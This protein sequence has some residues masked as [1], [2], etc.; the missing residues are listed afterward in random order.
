MAKNKYFFGVLL[1]QGSCCNTKIL[2]YPNA[3]ESQNLKRLVF[4]RFNLTR[5][6][7]SGVQISCLS[8]KKMKKATRIPI[9]GKNFNF[10]VKVHN[11]E[12]F[13][14]KILHTKKFELALLTIYSC[15]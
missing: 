14:S 3:I 6:A 1:F 4:D 10:R 7:V 13:S 9:A 12:Q 5:T 15:L 11:F 8:K 2:K